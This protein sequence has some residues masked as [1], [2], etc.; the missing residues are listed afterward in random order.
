MNTILAIFVAFRQHWKNTTANMWSLSFFFG[1]V[2]QIAIINHGRVIVT[3]APSTIKRSFSKIAVCEVI[4][5]QSQANAIPS[6]QALQGIQR[7]TAIEDGPLQRI[8][9]HML[10][11]TEVKIGVTEI[12]GKGNI[13]SLVMRD[14][15][16][17]EAYLNIIK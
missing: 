9:I 10:P 11:G 14:P 4:C 5:R 15:T 8:T 7:V 13:E 16:L 17:E 2:P 1:S 6:I 12:L 3:G